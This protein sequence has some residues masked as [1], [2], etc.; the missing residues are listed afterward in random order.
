MSTWI[1]K[2]VFYQIYP[3]SFYDSNNDGYGDLNGIIKKLDYVKEVGFNAIWLNPIYESPFVDGGYDISNFFKIDRRFGNLTILKK[4]LDEAHKRDIRIILDLVPG[5]TSIQNEIFVRSSYA[6]RNE[7]S[8]FFIWTNSCWQY[9]PNYKFVS[10]ISERDGNFLVNFF[11][12][13]PALN[14]GFNEINDPSW[15]ISYK[16]P[17]VQKTKEYIISIIKFYLELGVDGF[18]VDM[19]DSLVK[20][21]PR[22]DAT[23]EIWREIFSVIRPLYPEAAFVSEW[24]SPD[25]INKAG[26]DCDFMLNHWHNPYN[27]LFRY[28]EA[29][30]V[31]VFDKS[32]S[33]DVAG[34]I[35]DYM[36]WYNQIKDNG[37][38]GNITCN[39]DF[40]R[41]V[42]KYNKTQSLLA[43]LTVLSLPGVP[44]I[45]YGDEIGMEY[46]KGL[47]N[48]EGGYSRTGTR[49]P[50]QWNNKSYYGFSKVK[51][52][53]NSYTKNVCVKDQLKD[54]NSMLNKIKQFISFRKNEVSFESNNIEFINNTYPL[55][56]KRDQLLFIINPTNK[57][58]DITDYIQEY[59]VSY[60]IN[61]NGDTVSKPNSFIVL[62][63]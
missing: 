47:V 40:S 16:D 48:V 22:K 60:C 19:A 6:K 8:D 4:L 3:S 43:I 46:K 9:P 7:Y 23:S 15:Q 21:D 52:F 56:F 42:P 32:G 49:T 36:Y 27:K 31:S 11:S 18:R 44:F 1:K 24:S 38:I 25:A 28:D 30:G 51:P 61:Y 29:G 57:T 53:I 34:F 55:I 50:M 26:F 35:H 62:S 17:R 12:I 37:Y 14:Y 59:Q 58:Y 33:G 2:A 20:N 41:F 54:Q 13:Q 10:G 5:H 63:K 45:Y 39:H